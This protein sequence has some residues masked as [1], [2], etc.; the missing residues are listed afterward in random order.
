M[1]D[2]IIRYLSIKKSEHLRA[3]SYRAYEIHL[4]RFLS[5][6]QN[7][8]QGHTLIFNELAFI[9]MLS[10]YNYVP[11]SMMIWPKDACSRSTPAL[12]LHEETFPR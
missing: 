9:L 12:C 8:A 6:L 11:P 1:S 2:E 7:I 5:F 10:G 3:S 4:S